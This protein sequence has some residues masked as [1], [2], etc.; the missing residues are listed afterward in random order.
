MKRIWFAIIFLIVSVALCTGEQYYVKKVHNNIDT[1][2]EQAIQQLENKDK[3]QLKSSVK[4]IKEYWERYNNLLFSLSDHGVLDDLGA[5]IRTIDAEDEDI[6][7]ELSE[8]KALNEVFYEN[9]RISAAN[10]F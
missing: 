7:G 8:I 4:G 2:V 1:K 5:Q 6:A 10:V 9:Q 3:Q